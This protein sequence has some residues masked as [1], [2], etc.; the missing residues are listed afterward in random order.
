MTR[1]LGLLGAGELMASE[2]GQLA[3]PV[4]RVLVLGFQLLDNPLGHS[5]RAALRHRL[6]RGLHRP[7]CQ[8]SNRNRATS[9]TRLFETIRGDDARGRRQERKEKH[10][11]QQ[12]FIIS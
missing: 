5:E 6:S 8:S 2:P 7:E 9:N 12:P 11:T 3:V 10:Q 4:D 1:A